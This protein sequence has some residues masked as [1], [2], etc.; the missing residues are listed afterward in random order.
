MARG[1][2]LSSACRRS[3]GHSRDR[4]SY[5]D[6]SRGIRH[7]RLGTR[8]ACCLHGSRHRS[9]GV[10]PDHRSESSDCR[11]DAGRKVARLEA[12]Q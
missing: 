6:R 4:R 11:T 9:G 7:L 8:R 10:G 1:L 3:G 5:L 12:C 2:M